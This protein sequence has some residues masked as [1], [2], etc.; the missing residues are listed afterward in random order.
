M[1]LSL[2]EKRQI[3]LP[4]ELCDALGVKPGDFLDARVEGNSIVLRSSRKAALDAL[5]EISRALREAGV[6][7]EELQESGRQ[8]RK[9]IF[10]ERYPE[11]AKKH[12]V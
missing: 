4:A 5:K 7:L 3:T 12:G 10:R 9:E 6:T 8:V 1:R 11:L 2:R